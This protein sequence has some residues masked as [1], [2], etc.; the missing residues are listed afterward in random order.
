MLQLYWAAPMVHGFVA[1]AVFSIAFLSLGRYHVLREAASYWI[2]I[3]FAALGI[4]LVFYILVW[5]EVMFGR[6][7]LIATLPGTAAWLITVT[8]CLMGIGLLAVPL[9][10][11]PDRN[12]LTGK[13][14]VWSMLGWL[15]VMAVINFLIVKFESSLPAMVI[16]RGRFTPLLLISQ[17]AI[18]LVFV[19]GAVLSARQYLQTADKLL[20]YTAL[21]QIMFAFTMVDATLAGQRYSFWWYIDRFIWAVGVVIMA[22]GLLREYVRLYRQ[23]EMKN[24]QLEISLTERKQIEEALLESESKYR[25]LFEN[26]TEEVHFWKIVRDEEGEIKT[27]RLVDANLPTLK[28]WGKTLEEIKGKT[29]DEIFGPGATEHHMPIVQKIM[30]ERTGHVFEDYFPNLDKHFRF[31][32]VPVGDYFITTGA[33][34]SIIKKPHLELARKEAELRDA[35]RIAHIGS[36][37]WDAATDA[38]TGT[39]EL[40]RIF[41]L[42]PATQPM[43][44]FKEQDGLLYPHEEWQ[45]IDDAVRETVETGVGYQLDVQ[46]FRNGE[47]IWVTTRSEVLRD[48]DGRTIGLRGTVQDVTELKQAQDEMRELAQRLSSHMENSP[49]AVIEWGPDYRVSRWSEEAERVFGWSA[50]E[51]LGKRIDEVRWVYEADWPLVDKLMEDMNAGIRPRNVSPNRNYRKDGSIIY[52]EWYNS[53]LRNSSGVMTS[54]LSLV[55]DVT[56][57]ERSERE[58]R[59]QRAAAERHSAEIRSFVSSMAD[60]VVLFDTETKVWMANEA[61]EEL[62]GVPPG[63]PLDVWITQYE[64]R[65]PEGEAVPIEQYPSRRAL[66]GEQ[67]KGARFKMVSTWRESMVSISAAP[68]RDREG[69]VIGG[70]VSMHDISSLV[71]FER[72]RQELFDR[73]HHIAEVLQQAILPPDV[74]S[75]MMGLNIAVKYRPALKEAEIGGD[76]YD[77]FDLGD[78]RFAVLIGDVVG[79]GLKAAMRVSAARHAIRSYAYLD[80]RP[81][82]V[83]TLANN[84]LC[85]DTDDESGMLTL[86]YAVVDPGIGGMTY[87]SAGHESP[88]VCGADE[89]CDELSTHGLPIGIVPDFEYEQGSHRLDPGDLVVMVT[90]GITEA[91]APGLVM[92]GKERLIDFVTRHRNCTP[93]EIAT[94]LMDAATHHAGGQLQD[95]AAIVVLAVGKK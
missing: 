35:Q 41:G 73:E 68:V 8:D 6:R 95:D 33:D 83:L 91:R 4:G 89:V 38:T 71:D 27:W 39:D 32:S 64:L 46:A 54:V 12:A 63:T 7:S 36:W 51:M 40:R 67:I 30:T 16:G 56:E 86:F 11:W 93:G 57:R 47:R 76:F 82:R 90:D 62:L 15:A 1:M 24:R 78:G 79:K 42:D 28:T 69:Q 84:A 43:P 59:E 85:Q 74:P 94:G 21:A 55:L 5:P 34:I 31:T 49:L 10:R 53:V 65:T 2:G 77:V 44:D 45:R 13:K 20:A 14:W 50:E 19:V 26:M 37:Y 23:E 9:S 60:G 58:L 29:T 66:I 17:V 61:V 22:V 75:E 80:P 88:I 18:V 48:E 3:S 25:N 87:A 81:S 92:L 52:C 72:E 70:I